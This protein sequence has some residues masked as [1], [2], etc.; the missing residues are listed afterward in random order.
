MSSSLSKLIQF[1]IINKIL[2]N[3]SDCYHNNKSFQTF[4]SLYPTLK[5]CMYDYSINQEEF[6]SLKNFKQLNYNPAIIKEYSL[7]SKD[8]FNYITSRTDRLYTKKPIDLSF[9]HSI[10]QFSNITHLYADFSPEPSWLKNFTNLKRLVINTKDANSVKQLVDQFPSIKLEVFV[11]QEENINGDL[12]SI[13][14]DTL[15][16]VHIHAFDIIYKQ[17]CGCFDGD[18]VED[19]YNNNL[20]P[21]RVNS[22]YLVFVDV[23]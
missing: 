9:T 20:K 7:V 8:W 19:Y 23:F 1:E 11:N 13:G 15:E 12:S 4:P 5:E 16:F 14:Y 22:I 18:T 3:N 2:N 6:Y 10:Y 21:W 17:I